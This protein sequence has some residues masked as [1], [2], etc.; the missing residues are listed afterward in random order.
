[1]KNLT[2]RWLA[3]LL[4]S[5][6]LFSCSGEGDGPIGTGLEGI[7]GV[8]AKG[9]AI[10]NAPVTLRGR[11]GNRLSVN[12]GKDG[13]YRFKDLSALAPPYLIRVDVDSKTKLYGVSMGPGNSNLHPLSD[14]VVR[15]WFY[16]HRPNDDIDNFFNGNSA[17]DDTLAEAQ[18]NATVD[19]I[20]SLLRLAYIKF[21]VSNTFDFIHSSFRARH[22]DDNGN[23]VDGDSFD[24]L[25]DNIRVSIDDYS[26]TIELKDPDTGL[27]GRILV[28]FDLSNDLGQL[29]EIKPQPPS[30]IK[31]VA[32]GNDSLVLYWTSAYDNVG[33]AGYNIYNASGL[34]G[35]SA[36][37]FYIDQISWNINSEYCYFI[38]AFDAAGNVSEKSKACFSQDVPASTSPPAPA[39]NLSAQAIGSSSI[40]L[41]W[42][43]SPD[44][45]IGYDIYRQASG[46]LQALKI[47][48]VVNSSFD[49]LNLL[50][51]SEYC[52]Y[53]KAIKFVQVSGASAYQRLDSA[54]SNSA[55]ATTSSESTVDRLA[56]I[57]TATPGSST[58]TAPQTVTLSCDDQAGSGCG[59]I[60]FTTDG[61][62]PTTQ[63][64][65][66]GSPI[67]ISRATLLQFFAVD[68]AGNVETVKAAF[69]DIDNIIYDDFND[70]VLDANWQVTLDGVTNWSYQE[71]ASE[72]VIS[73]ITAAAK[74][75]VVWVKL[76]RDIAPLDDFSLDFNIAWDSA[77]SSTAMQR[78][79]MR[80][81][82]GN[83]NQV[84]RVEYIDDWID[85]SGARRAFI[86]TA[87]TYP[88]VNNSLP[89]AGA[90]NISVSR[91]N[92]D[93]S[94]LWNG[95]AMLSGV[96]AT[97]IT[98][99]ELYAAAYDYSVRPS[100]FGSESIDL[101]N[102]RQP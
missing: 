95:S 19:V 88:A 58:V 11:N 97:P 81:W 10:A 17:I 42:M 5:M 91:V 45:V 28:R 46:D 30:D 47:A 67:T 33:V 9:F 38:E 63:S 60:Y 53:N 31:I 29:D 69:Y 62:T 3:L 55:C 7:S 75:Q 79:G 102:L 24:H 66:Y 78:L 41:A 73:D 8:A 37:P 44:Q 101:I 54:P 93:V 84:L 71:S 83:G 6:L 14:I 51:D 89:L 22:H 48:T 64:S 86:G 36:Y 23:E 70:Q 18:I 2:W 61:S 98:R 32:G 87:Y 40:N 15:N 92:G 52:Y 56:P 100:L 39:T 1:M 76:S 13:H 90:A 85:W 72:L 59:N 27:Y 43:P 96:D 65:V 20:R 49:D 94:I 57:T 68:V 35:E 26:I 12:S 50:A 80:M 99:V 4:L 77:G 16:S 21:G 74:D 82:D 34:L 25:L